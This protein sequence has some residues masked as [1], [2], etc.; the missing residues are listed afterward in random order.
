MLEFLLLR[1]LLIRGWDH[2]IKL[3]RFNQINANVNS[4]SKLSL[5]EN[6]GECRP[7]RVKFKPLTNPLVTQYVEG[8]V[9]IATLGKDFYKLPCEFAL[10]LLRSTLDKS[11]EASALNHIINLS[12]SFKLL[13]LELNSVKLILILDC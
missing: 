7:I 5:K 6:L 2:I 8:L 12:E 10:R 9:P 1:E 3:S 13:L 11:E 4:P